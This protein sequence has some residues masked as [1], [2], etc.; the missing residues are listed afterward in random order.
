VEGLGASKRVVIWDNAI[1][2]LNHDQLLTVFGHEM[3]HYILGHARLLTAMWCGLM[4]VCLFAAYHATRWMLDRWGGA[5]EIHGMKDWASMPLMMLVVSVVAFVAE[6]VTNSF[7]RMLEHDADVYG[8]EVVH[9]IVADPRLEAAQAFQTLENLAD[10]EPNRF[11]VLWLYDHP[12]LGD[13]VRFALAYDPWSGGRR[14]KY[15][16]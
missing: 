4:L 13:R 6:P 5:W 7:S 14:P 11:I 8:L 3:G 12:P 9:G 15:F 16:K 2:E 1:A 10:P